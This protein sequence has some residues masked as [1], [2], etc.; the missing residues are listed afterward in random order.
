MKLLYI[1]HKPVKSWKVSYVYN[2]F[3]VYYR[4]VSF[5]FQC[6]NTIITLTLL[7][8]KLHETC[9]INHTKMPTTIIGKKSETYSN[10]KEACM[11]LFATQFYDLTVLNSDTVFPLL[12]H[13]QWQ[14]QI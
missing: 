13:L 4:S 10:T 2:S 5:Y 6:K 11:V 7:L 9:K 14:P 12:R 3:L 1:K 8:A